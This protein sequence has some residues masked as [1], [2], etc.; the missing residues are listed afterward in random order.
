MYSYVGVSATEYHWNIPGV[1]TFRQEYIT[2]IYC[3]NVGK[4]RDS[5]LHE[6]LLR[7]SKKERRQYVVA[8]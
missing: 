4:I 1:G 5:Q 7:V 8:S 3:P 6:G 2:I